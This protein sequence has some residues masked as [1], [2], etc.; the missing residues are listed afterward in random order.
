M[1]F[2]NTPPKKEV[3]DTPNYINCGATD[4]V[5]VPEEGALICFICGASWM[6]TATGVSHAFEHEGASHETGTIT[7]TYSRKQ[8]FE[9]LLQYQQGKTTSNLPQWVID[10]VAEELRKRKVLDWTSLTAVHISKMC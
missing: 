6:H 7:F 8:H 5:V 1:R 9:R 2:D 3:V 10:R 4:M